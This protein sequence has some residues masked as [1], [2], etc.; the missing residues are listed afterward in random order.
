MTCMAS[1]LVPLSLGVILAGLSYDMGKDALA[2]D[3]LFET[4]QRDYLYF[5]MD[6]HLGVLLLLQASKALPFPLSPDSN[7]RLPS[8][9]PPINTTTSFS[10]SQS[11]PERRVFHEHNRELRSPFPSPTRSLLHKFQQKKKSGHASNPPHSSSLSKKK[12]EQKKKKKEEKQELKPKVTMP[13]PQP[14]GS[15]S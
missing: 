10:P 5:I 12:N 6:S 13:H 15:I 1:S 7:C 3:M 4:Q 9:P 2:L 14:H 11:I 8:P